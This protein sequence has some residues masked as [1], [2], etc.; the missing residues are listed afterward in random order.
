MN[1]NSYTDQVLYHYTS[2]DVLKVILNRRYIW[3]TAIE[4]LADKME[5][6]YGRDMVARRF[7]LEASRSKIPE[8]S[9]RLLNCAACTRTLPSISE[10]IRCSGNEPVKENEQF[11]WYVAC[12]SEN[13]DSLRLCCITG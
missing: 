2:L 7:E 1:N 9:S 12:F 8:K 13:R 3:A 10:F 11:E 5:L 6:V 4:D